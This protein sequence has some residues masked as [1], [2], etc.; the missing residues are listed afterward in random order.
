MLS[1]HPATSWNSG[2]HAPVSLTLT[3]DEPAT[4]LGL[5]P[6]MKPENGHVALVVVTLENNM[7]VGHSQVRRVAARFI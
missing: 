3:F 6:D 2:R 5:C 7:R 1:R 4:V